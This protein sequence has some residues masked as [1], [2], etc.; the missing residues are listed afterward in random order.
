MNS[1]VFP[2]FELGLNFTS[3]QD[4]I[5]DARLLQKRSPNG[6]ASHL[7]DCICQIQM[8]EN[9]QRPLKSC[10]C[11]KQVACLC[12]HAYV[13]VYICTY[14]YTHIWKEYSCKMLVMKLEL[15]KQ[16]IVN[17]TILMYRLTRKSIRSTMGGKKLHH[18]HHQKQNKKTK[19]RTTKN[20]PCE[21][22]ALLGIFLILKISAET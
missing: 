1:F 22:C 20:P 4:G 19:Q 11:L 5:S 17:A 10:L 21:S 9:W 13:C 16:Q 14:V 15:T 3:I 12:L 8:L 6:E 7:V 2:I 18:P